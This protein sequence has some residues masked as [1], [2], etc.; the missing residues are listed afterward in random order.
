MVLQFDIQRTDE[1]FDG[2]KD[3]DNMESLKDWIN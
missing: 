2:W 1:L 3:D